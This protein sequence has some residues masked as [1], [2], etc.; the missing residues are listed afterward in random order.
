MLVDAAYEIGKRFD[1][2]VIVDA[3]LTVLARFHLVGSHHPRDDDA[4]TAVSQI[5]IH[6]GQL[7]CRKTVVPHSFKGSRT[8]KAALRF[9]TADVTCIK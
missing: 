1:T 9:N 8:D 6:F 2:A 5:F 3:D 7:F 4:G